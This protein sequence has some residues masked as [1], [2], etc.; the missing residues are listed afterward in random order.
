MRFFVTCCSARNSCTINPIQFSK[1]DSQYRKQSY[2]SYEN[3]RSFYA[4]LKILSRT[5]FSGL[6]RQGLKSPSTTIFVSQRK[7]PYTLLKF[8]CQAFSAQQIYNHFYFFRELLPQTPKR[9]ILPGQ[10]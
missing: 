10:W 2:N 1:I 6:F 5:F 4:F 9:D 3:G 7:A 8:L